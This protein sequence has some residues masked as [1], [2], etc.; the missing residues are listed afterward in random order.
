MLPLDRCSVDPDFLH[1]RMHE[2]LTNSW[3]GHQEAR[4]NQIITEAWADTD[5]QSAEPW[6]RLEAAITAL[7][8]TAQPIVNMFPA[9]AW[10]H[11]LRMLPDCAFVGNGGLTLVSSRE[12]RR[13]VTEEL[14]SRSTALATA[15]L[16]VVYPLH[17]ALR[18]SIIGRAITQA[19][20]LLRANAKG[21]PLATSRLG[22]PELDKKHGAW[23]AIQAFD[24]R[25]A[26]LDA[27][28]RP[29]PNW[30]PALMP[31]P[32]VDY[33]IP[34]AIGPCTLPNPDPSPLD[35]QKYS[36]GTGILPLPSTLIRPRWYHPHL[37]RALFA[38]RLVWSILN[39]D[40]QAMSAARALGYIKTSKPHLEAA[41][42][43][44]DALIRTQTLFPEENDVGDLERFIE[45]A[46]WQDDSLSIATPVA[47]E[48]PGGSIAFD[49]DCSWR[50][51]F[52]LRVPAI[53]PGAASEEWSR[54]FEVNLQRAIDGTEWEPPATIR[55]LRGRHLKADDGRII[56]DIDSIAMRDGLA[57]LIDAKVFLRKGES[58]GDYKATRG[59]C[60]DLT[61]AFYRWR[62][63][64]SRLDQHRIGPNYDLQAPL[65]LVP[66]IVTE[67]T[68]FVPGPLQAVQHQL[69][70][71]PIVS[72][73]ELLNFLAK[74]RN[75]PG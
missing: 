68:H 29:A 45:E 59:I 32:T 24:T 28:E 65:Q 15:S 62:L 46:L 70:I 71:P 48:S 53:P 27:Y 21:V 74:P 63:K 56:T 17:G 55:P 57:I 19:R 10:L 31:E 72:H 67:T 52:D 33:L 38:H 12:E 1:L 2:V 44:C 11:F 5:P 13:W 58:R 26:K 47:R 35:R 66:L 34:P 64:V 8:A 41:A 75:S 9:Y 36:L 18:L 42:D 4:S 16:P 43:R 30:H 22:W 51:L 40:H 54:Q 3:R 7:E 50:R 14:S 23:Q 60:S 25:K 20:I 73:V 69:P 37:P 49:I 6:Q 61:R 39:E